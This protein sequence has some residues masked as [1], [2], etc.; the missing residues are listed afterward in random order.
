MHASRQPKRSQEANQLGVSQIWR[1]APT[2]TPT[3][4][5]CTKLLLLQGHPS[6]K[7]RHARP[8][9]RVFHLKPQLSHHLLQASQSLA[10]STS[11][12]SC[13]CP[14]GCSALAV[15]VDAYCALFFG[16]YPQRS[17]SSVVS[18]RTQASTTKHQLY[19]T[20]FSS[21]GGK[22][23]ASSPL[24]HG[25]KTTPMTGSRVPV[26]VPALPG[27]A[28]NPRPPCCIWRP[29]GL[30]GREKKGAWAATKAQ[31]PDRLG[32]ARFLETNNLKLQVVQ[33]KQEL[34]SGK[35]EHFECIVH[36]SLKH[37]YS[38]PEGARPTSKPAI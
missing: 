26:R 25:P 6:C 5:T 13:K 23:N 4:T 34:G 14:G 38:A 8:A 32:T 33:L 30:R 12:G 31:M 15:A 20:R 28:A 27:T 3:P 35:Q 19:F 24:Q 11:K 21:E 37:S 1:R 2:S 7:H 36:N 18:V 9:R 17:E 10:S 29:L 16:A 22:Y